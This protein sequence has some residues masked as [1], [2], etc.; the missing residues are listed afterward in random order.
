MEYLNLANLYNTLESTSLKTKKSYIIAS[1]LENC[2]TD[3]IEDIVL[4]LSGSVYP[5]WSKKDIGI[6]AKLMINAVSKAYGIK[7]S[8]VNN[9]WKELGDIGEVAERLHKKKQQSTLFSQPLTVSRSFQNLRKITGIEGKKSQQKKTDL[10]CE[11]LTSS[12]ALEAKYIT[13]TILGELRI[14]VAEGIIRDAIAQ[15][16][17]INIYWKEI[18]NQKINSEKRADMLLKDTKDRKINIDEKMDK[19]FEKTSSKLYSLFKNNNT[20]SIIE[21]TDNIDL[22]KK[23]TDIFISSDKDLA[24]KLKSRITDT[25]ESAYNITNDFGLIASISSQEGLEGFENISLNPNRPIRAMLYQKVENIN[26]AFEKVGSPARLEYKYDGFRLQ[27]HCKDGKIYLFTRKLE[28]VTAQFPDIVEY[29]KQA[30]KEQNFILDSEI[31]G[32]D[33]RKNKYLP[34]QEISRR[35]KRKHNINR[36]MEKVPVQ[37]RIFDCMLIGEHNL[38]NSPLKERIRKLTDIIKDTPNVSMA[39][40]IETDNQKDA[41]RFYKTSLELGNEGIMIKNTEAPYMPGSRVGTGVKVKPVMETLD[42]VITSAQ[43]GE[44][45]RCKWFATFELACRNGSEDDFLTIGMMGTGIKEKSE[46]DSVSFEYLTELIDPLIT[47][48]E[49][50]KVYIKPSIVIEVAYEEIQKSK[51]YSSGFALRFPR[52]V[53]LRPDLPPEDVDS[54]SRVAFLYKNQRGRETI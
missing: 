20:V 34:F 40:Y 27:I 29:I 14:G 12:Q 30:I 54:I 46:E 28:N 26:E 41:E 45:K 51:K 4:L 8:V 10:I 53:R 5:A 31:V 39:E 25:I 21:L 9:K 3:E 38:I 22:N 24:S 50:K 17:F 42:L 2:S 47:K 18:L 52:L 49:E 15:A 44:G 37:V 33:S 48:R 7:K 19:Y 13:R 16:Y 32:F 11:L 23:E 1:F 35:I 6:A 36:L 43:Q